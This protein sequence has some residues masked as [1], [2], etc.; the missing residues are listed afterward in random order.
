MGR[1]KSTTRQILPKNINKEE[2]YTMFM[3]MMGSEVDINIIHP[4]YLVIWD[5]CQSLIK[6]M[7]KFADTDSILSKQFPELKKAMKE[8]RYFCN[9]FKDALGTRKSYD[10]MMKE[11]NKNNSYVTLKNSDYMKNL[12]ITRR[13]LQEHQKYIQSAKDITTNLF[14]CERFIYEYPGPELTLFPFSSF[15][16]KNIWDEPRMKEFKNIKEYILICLCVFYSKIK[17]IVKLVL[18]AD[19]DVK[20]FSNAVGQQLIAARKQI[21]G[22]N[23]AFDKIEQSIDLLEDNFDGYYRDMIQSKNPNLI[24]ENFVLD[25]SKNQ[26]HDRGT[27]M[28]FKRI[29]KFYQK[30]TAGKINDPRLQHL[31][32]ALDKNFSL[33]DNNTDESTYRPQCSDSDDE[34]D[35]VNDNAEEEKLAENTQDVSTQFND[36]CELERLTHVAPVDNNDNKREDVNDDTIPNAAKIRPSSLTELTAPTINDS[37]K[38][39]IVHNTDDNLVSRTVRPKVAEKLTTLNDQIDKNTRDIESSNLD[40][41]T[42]SEWVNSQST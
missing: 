38:L 42:Y 33:L 27:N 7:L 23:R 22:C 10:D 11:G 1:G 40:V 30:Q 32:N 2:W 12:I 14:L 6:N 3:Q 21:R 15:E 20:G 19:V 35:E 17:K 18:S 16:L 31:F 25:V 8:I 37:A 28:E 36:N 9:Q 13:N 24:V 39:N 26:K 41:D 34:P 5:E 29:M 4:K